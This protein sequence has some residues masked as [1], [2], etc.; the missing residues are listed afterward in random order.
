[1]GELGVIII[2]G[3]KYKVH[4]KIAHFNRADCKNILKNNI[5]YID[6]IKPVSNINYVKQLQQKNLDKFNECLNLSISDYNIMYNYTENLQ[7]HLLHAFV[8]LQKINLMTGESTTILYP[9]T[10]S[11]KNINY[12]ETLINYKS[13]N[14]VHK[15]AEG[16]Y[17]TKSGFIL[18]I[19]KTQEKTS[20]LELQEMLYSDEKGYY[21]GKKY[22][23]V[24]DFKNLTLEN[25]KKI[26]EIFSKDLLNKINPEI[27]ITSMIYPEHDL[28]AW[29][30]YNSGIYHDQKYK[31]NDLDNLADILNDRYVYNNILINK[32]FNKDI[33][34][35]KKPEDEL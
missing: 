29:K 33:I 21:I 3:I 13:I 22:G 24:W 6:S 2:N 12:A 35:D 10:S 4:T 5:S 11:S 8:V 19:D 26:D 27:D 7:K 15:I 20:Q 1:M 14:E 25:V 17:I 32:N 23:D 18:N 16:L 28:Y 9:I 31:L 30:L 34:V